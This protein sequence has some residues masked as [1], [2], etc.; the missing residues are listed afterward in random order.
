MAPETGP[1][2]GPDLCRQWGA[3]WGKRLRLHRC[4]NTRCHGARNEK[5]TKRPRKHCKKALRQCGHLLSICCQF[6]VNF[7]SICDHFLSAAHRKSAPSFLCM[8]LIR[9]EIACAHICTCTAPCNQMQFGSFK[10][11][12]GNGA[13]N[14]KGWF[15]FFRA[16][17]DGEWYQEVR[18]HRTG[19]KVSLSA[20]VYDH[21]CQMP[22]PL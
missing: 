7:K 18:P 8:I 2:N 9:F 10:F 19:K 11:F 21:T 14:L 13:L 6:A 22:P 16:R 15:Y 12:T 20:F 17:I 5:T 4:L 1:E 3:T